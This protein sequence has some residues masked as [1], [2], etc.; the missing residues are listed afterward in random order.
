MYSELETIVIGY[1][2]ILFN[3]NQPK[4][5]LSYLFETDQNS[6]AQSFIFLN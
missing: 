2:Y 1:C 3:L 4:S 5:S 6:I